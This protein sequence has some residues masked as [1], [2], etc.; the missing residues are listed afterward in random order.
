MCILYVLYRVK[1]ILCVFRHQIL[2]GLVQ[3]LILYHLEQ[4]RAVSVLYVSISMSPLPPVSLQYT[5]WHDIEG[6]EPRY[7][8]STGTIQKIAMQLK[9]VINE[10]ASEYLYIAYQQLV[11]TFC[12]EVK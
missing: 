1:N 5:G 8:G 7:A 4:F 9:Q 3:P 10:S 12:V 11:F 2:R 6:T